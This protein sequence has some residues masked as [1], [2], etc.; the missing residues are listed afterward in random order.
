MTKENYIDLIREH[1]V[2]SIFLN[3]DG[4]VDAMQKCYEKGKYDGQ[5][6]F[7]E[8]LSKMDYLSDNINYMIQEWKN[9]KND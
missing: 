6:E 9:K 1:N 2:H 5:D 8:W 7:L 4:L 3:Q